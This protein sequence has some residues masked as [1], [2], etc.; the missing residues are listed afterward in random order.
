M[1]ASPEI[2]RLIGENAIRKGD[3]AEA[4]PYL[5]KATKGLHGN[6]DGWALLGRAYH[7]AA[8]TTTPPRRYKKAVELAPAQHQLPHH[9]GLILGQAGELDEGL[10]A[11]AEGDEH[12][13]LQGRG[14][15]DQPRLGLP[16]HGQ[17]PGVDRAY[18]KAL[19]LDPKQEQAALGLGWAYSYTKDYDKAIAPTTRR[20]RSTRRTR[21]PTRTSAS[22]WCYFFKRQLAERGIRE[23]AAAA[24]RNV[25]ALKD[26]DRQASRRRSPRV[27]R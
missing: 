9:L 3:Y 8:A 14:G 22:R 16:Q 7:D 18:Q 21:P 15:L 4:I 5:E 2:Q 13:G 25:D 1:P 24:G 20:S 12:A 19:E 23:K 27:R 26:Q 10:A 17:A 11:A 6:A